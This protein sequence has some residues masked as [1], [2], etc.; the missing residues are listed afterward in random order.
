METE[1]WLT[2]LGLGVASYAIRLGGFLLALRLPRTGP[3]ARGMDALPGCLIMSLV[4]LMMLKAGPLEQVASL[5]VLLIAVKT[6]NLPISMIAG[7][8]FVAG[9]RLMGF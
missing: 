1:I 4:A 3:W 9:A 6:R 2:I 7:M 8:I 5:F